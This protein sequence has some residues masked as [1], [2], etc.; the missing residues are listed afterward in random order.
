MKKVSVIVP[1]YNTEQYLKKCIESLLNQTLEEIEIVI[2]NDGST[3]HSK[4]I[5]EEYAN[6]YKDKVKLFSKENGGQASAR[7]LALKNCEGKYIGFLDSDDYVKPEMFE[8]LYKK[9][10]AEILD[11]VGCGYMDFTYKEGK[12]VVLKEYIGQKVCRSNREMFRDS[13]VSPFIN[14]YKSSVIKEAKA[15]FPEGVI[16]EDTAFFANLIPYI[17]SVG[18]IEEALACRLRR[19]NSTMTIVEPVKVA[20]IFSVI[21]HILDFYEK[22]GLKE[23]REE[24]EYFC[25]RI[26]LCG[27]LERI[28]KVPDSSERKKLIDETWKMIQCNFKNRKSNSYFRNTK[29]DFYMKYANRFILKIVCEALHIKGKTEREYV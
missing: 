7:N 25:I 3:D 18:Y 11:Y 1:V 14:F 22:R 16:Y 17:K 9:A 28:S 27:S 26:L 21:K 29:K 23:Y 15:F 8:K 4:Q 10:E 20:Q 19:E 12:Q 5:L 13:L 24:V 6:N 2:V